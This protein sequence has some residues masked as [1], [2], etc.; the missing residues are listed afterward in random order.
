VVVTDRK[1]VAGPW[2]FRW[3]G[4]SLWKLVRSRDPEFPSKALLEVL[5]YGDV[6]RVCLVKD[7][8]V[9]LPNEDWVE[10]AAVVIENKTGNVVAIVG[11]RSV[12]LEGFNRASQARR[13]PG[14]SFKPYVYA[15]ALDDGLTQISEVLDGPISLG[16]WSPKN[17]S[18]GFRGMLP[19]RAAF[20]YS[21]NTVAVRLILRT[22]VDKVQEMAMAAGVSKVRHDVT[23]AL[24][25]SEVTPLEHTSAI[26]TFVRMGKAI[27]P[28]FVT[29]LKDS[30]DRE[31][32]RAG[33]P[34]TLPG[35]TAVLPGPPG[36]DA[37]W[38]GPRREDGHHQQLHRRVVRRLHRH[39]H[40]RR[41]DRL[42]RAGD[43]RAR[44]D[45]RALGAACVDGDRG[46]AA[47]AEG[48]GHCAAA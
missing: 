38:G 36:I 8:L 35:T 5:S 24:G 13:Q 6:Y 15:A 16:G 19:L 12:G 20:A 42:G 34:I 33:Q 30:F 32:G 27:P 47:A 29:R 48:R 41:V 3:S 44:R 25:S 7:D 46:C 10:G 1:V 40:H 45:R 2:Q 26:S 22:G 31:V 39:P 17:Y 37:V 9:E 4:N 43:A 23:I 21:L 11:G 14:S 18:G 28:V